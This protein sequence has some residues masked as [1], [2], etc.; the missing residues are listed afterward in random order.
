MG[1]LFGGGSKPK[2][3]PPPP[4]PPTIEQ[5][6][7]ASKLAAEAQ[8]VRIARGASGRASTML[9]GGT[10]VKDDESSV[11]TAKKKLLGS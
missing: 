7:T 4:P 10:G 11:E 6:D 1:S 9:T 3:P 8:R 2:D 5:P